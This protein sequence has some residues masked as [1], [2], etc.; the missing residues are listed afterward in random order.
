[1][2]VGT[3]N[4]KDG[5]DS[6]TFST[7][8][9]AGVD[10]LDA[11]E[12]KGVPLRLCGGL[13]CWYHSHAA[14]AVAVA[15]R[16]HYSDI[17]LAAKY[18]D[19]QR[20]LQLLTSLGYREDAASATVPGIRRTIFNSKNGRLHGDIFYDAIAFCHYVEFRSRLE[21]DSPT[22]PLS[23]LLM[24]KM[25]VVDLAEKD[26]IDVQMLLLD[27]EFGDTDEECFNAA[28]IAGI[29]GSDWGLYRTA[30]LNAEKMR[31][32]TSSSTY[33]ELEQQRRVVDQVDRLH[34]L[35]DEAP[36]SLRWRL[37]SVVGDHVRWYDTVDDN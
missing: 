4:D 7:L 6:G 31:S 28:R 14:R 34:R 19:R 24:Q 29:C 21:R 26:V 5:A 3:P 23:E 20:V 9:A 37:R 35:L 25:Q 36:K 33:L 22:L 27:H 15:A 2:R 12:S 30:T 10:L 17:D 11:A 1:M 13:A 32:L 8:L 16:R 18:T